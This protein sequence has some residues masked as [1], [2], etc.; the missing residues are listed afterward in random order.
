[1]STDIVMFVTKRD[2]RTEEVKFDKITERINK[3]VDK[4]ERNL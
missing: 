4:N 3:L 1:M 2:G